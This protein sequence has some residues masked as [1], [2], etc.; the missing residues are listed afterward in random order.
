MLILCDTRQQAGKHENIEKYFIKSGIEFDRQALYVGDYIIAN[1]G[2]RAV[3]TKYGVIELAHDIMS[4]D[5]ERFRR[6]CERAQAAGIDLLVL[7]EEELP[8]GGLGNWESPMDRFGKPRTL[9]KGES[10]KLALLTMTVKYDVRFRFCSPK[11]T[12]RC[13]M[14]Y[15]A[16]GVMPGDKAK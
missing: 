2:R 12:G 7:I 11:Q 9:V 3:D 10:L 6:E 13:I 1:D 5:H 16:E 4:E 15:L 14:E 8:P